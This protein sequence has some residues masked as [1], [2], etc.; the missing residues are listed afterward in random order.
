MDLTG[1]TDGYCGH[2]AALEPIVPIFSPF[3]ENGKDR[4]D[5]KSTG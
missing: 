4:D 5:G 2:W 1:A 3:A